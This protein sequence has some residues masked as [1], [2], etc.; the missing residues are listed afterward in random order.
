[1]PEEEL[2]E[3]Y[4]E[5]LDGVVN[6]HIELYEDRPYDMVGR[7]IGFSDDYRPVD[8]ILADFETGSVSLKYIDTQD[9]ESELRREARDAFA[10]I[11]D[12]AEWRPMPSATRRSVNSEEIYDSRL[13][14]NFYAPRAHDSAEEFLERF[15]ES[16][17]SE[18]SEIE[19]L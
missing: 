18:F 8:F 14:G 6:L 2:D 16:D 13:R 12:E 10:E 17:S 3:S 15:T 7:R 9:E 19:V 11:L 4:R 5:V 1:M